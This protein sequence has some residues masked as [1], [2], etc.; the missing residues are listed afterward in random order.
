MKKESIKKNSEYRK[1][2]NSGKSLANRYLVMYV[3][4]NNTDKTRI[5]ISVSKKV[6]NSVVRHRLTRLIR[7][8]YRLNE[9]K[10]QIGKDI[11][12]V[13][14]GRTDSGVH[15][16]NQVCHL[17]YLIIDIR[18]NGGGNS[19]NGRLIAE[20]L[21]TQE[22]EHCVGGDNITPQ[23]N[24]YHGK[25]FLLTG[26]YTF[27]AAESFA[28]DLKES[29]L[30]TL[31]GETTAGD[32]GC[33]PKNFT[34]KYGICFRIPTREPHFSPKGFPMEGVGIEPHY[35]ARQSV[36]DLFEDRDTAIEYV[37]NELM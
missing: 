5:G 28:I 25:L 29:G 34:S 13:A 20:Y 32:T 36:V 30:A 8:I 24:A 14:S 16:Y 9:Q 35:E 12:V 18:R 33:A 4:N 2:Y 10:I 23:P 3:L 37:L 26:N 6:G 15:A 22:Q 19:N 21:I 17:P 7:E 1:V 31:V 27:S 11:V